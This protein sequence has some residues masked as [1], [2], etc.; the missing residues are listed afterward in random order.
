M[1]AL[2]FNQR[3]PRGFNYSPRYYDPE[4]EA[5]EERKKIVL[6]E[7]YRSP[8]EKAREAAEAD[9][10]ATGAD[11]KADGSRG[12][13]AGTG[14]STGAGYVPGAYLR[15]HVASRRNIH[16]ADMMRRRRRKQRSVYVLAGMLALIL[17]IVWML[18][19]KK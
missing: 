12:A 8:A 18:Y 7:K 14:S 1:A 2:F 6:G 16:A 9:A 11:G 10:A 17:L 5:R 13:G 19:F 15:E 3:K 4:A